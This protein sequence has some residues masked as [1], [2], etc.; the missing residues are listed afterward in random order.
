MV[1]RFSL[2]GHTGRP[3][4]HPASCKV[5]TGSFPEVKQAGRGFNHSPPSSAEVKEIVE[6]YFSSPSGPSGTV[7][8]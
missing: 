8:G 7:L 6:L 1:A 4:A 5:G 2:P 3:E